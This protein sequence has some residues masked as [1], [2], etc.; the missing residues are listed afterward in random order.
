MTSQLDLPIPA[1]TPRCP[2][3]PDLFTGYVGE[4]ATGRPGQMAFDLDRTLANDKARRLERIETIRAIASEVEDRCAIYGVESCHADDWTRAADDAQIALR[5]RT[6]RKAY[7][8]AT[9]YIDREITPGM[10]RGASATIRAI[11]RN[12]G[13]SLYLWEGARRRP[14]HYKGDDSNAMFHVRLP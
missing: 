14:D 3:T 7:R 6:E 11:V 1:E 4:R 13:G 12:H 8:D 10:M 5:F 2:I 9:T